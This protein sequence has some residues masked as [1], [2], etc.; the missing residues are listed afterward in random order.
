MK[1][2]VHGRKKENSCKLKLKF[3][4]FA[5]IEK[6]KKFYRGK[7]KKKEKKLTFFFKYNEGA[8]GFYEA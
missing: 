8:L 7:F 6:R 2:R 5:A 4:S 3:A 1:N